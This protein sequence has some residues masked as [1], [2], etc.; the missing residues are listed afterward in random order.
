[1]RLRHLCIMAL[2]A[3][4]LPQ[5]IIAQTEVGG[6][7][8]SDSAWT[9]AGG[10][11][12]V[13]ETVRVLEGVTLVIEPKVTVRFDSTH[14][15]EV[16]GTLVAKG[17]ATDSI[18]FRSN[19]LSSQ[20]GS[21]GS[22]RFDGTS[23]DAIFDSLG[24][25]VSGCIIEFCRIEYGGDIPGTN[26][27]GAIHCDYASPFISH[28]TITGSSASGNGYGGG[29]F[30]GNSSPMIV[31]NVIS[32]NYAAYGGGIF[33]GGES[34]PV[35]LDNLIEGN[36][37]S[38]GGGICSF[39]FPKSSA[40]IS[41][42]VIR[43]N[44]ASAC[45]GG[46]YTSGATD[47]DINANEITGNSATNG[48]GICCSN[49]SQFTNITHNIIGHNSAS[50]KGGGLFCISSSPTISD[51]SIIDN[52]A[53]TYGG[54]IYT[55]GRY[56]HLPLSLSHNNITANSASICGGIFADSSY[57]VIDHNNLF[58]MGQYELYLNEVSEDI[59]A[60]NNWW[61]ITNPDS[62]EV[63]IYDYH[64]DTTLA[65]V[66]FNPFLTTPAIGNPTL[67]YSVRLK[68]DSTYATDLTTDLWIGAKMY[69]Q[70]EGEDSDS[71]SQDQTTVSLRGNFTDITGIQVTLTE[72]D[73]ASGIFRGTATI[74][75][76]SVEDVS[77]AAAVGE[78]LTV[79][80]DVDST[81]F[82]TVLVGKEGIRERDKSSLPKEITLF[83]NY[84]NPFNSNTV[85]SYQLSG[86]RPHRTTLKI[87]NIFGQLIRTLVDEKQAPGYY[88]VLWDGRN[89]SAEEVAS[90]VYL[91]RLLVW[92]FHQVRKMVILK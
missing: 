8:A 74:D 64:D 5:P 7:I 52:S 20:P 45:G 48:G 88:S 92:D 56:Y 9:F 61:G 71:F 31:G 40:L 28:N 76:I 43:G 25:Y 60:I 66:Y 33:C 85:I 15:L 63:K 62:I 12:I 72:T 50:D 73:T 13:V 57:L 90:G 16:G 19:L 59:D 87:Y 42:N 4:V 41:D 68:S 67:V 27:D 69:F 1:M 11:Y 26:Y 70:L 24:N 78:T 2:V 17:T 3:V 47:R 29:I 6:E 86:I 77:I 49:S 89:K 38:M 14:S 35:I 75:T 34:Y 55:F 30:C 54:G 81:K 80:S 32:G 46:I 84:P 39:Y 65:E 37:A 83:H 51:N 23:V 10:P 79:S 44:T 22:I 82:T 53:S 58:N 91:C 18:I 36:S 21:W